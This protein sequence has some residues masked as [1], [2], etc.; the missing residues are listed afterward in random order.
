MLRTKE[1]P[2]QKDRQSWVGRAAYALGA[3]P[4][5]TGP[6]RLLI[7]EPPFSEQQASCKLNRVGIR[8]S[9]AEQFNCLVK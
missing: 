8:E 6:S 4:Y 7:R 1:R 9:L 3:A 5:V 2:S